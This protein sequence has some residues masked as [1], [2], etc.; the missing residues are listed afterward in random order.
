MPDLDAVAWILHAACAA[1]AVF[2]G[3]WS[4]RARH[5]QGAGDHADPRRSKFL[6]AV[7]L[8][9]VVASGT[10]LLGLGDGSTLPLLASMTT[11]TLIGVVSGAL[12]RRDDATSRPA[13]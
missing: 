12:A 2:F 1:M 5:G 8:V 7:M 10:S 6:S 13:A 9:C 3:H 4:V 11:A